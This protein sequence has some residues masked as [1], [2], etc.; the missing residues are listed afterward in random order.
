KMFTTRFFLL[1]LLSTVA[2]GAFNPA[3]AVKDA[4]NGF[5]NTGNDAVKNY[6]LA[7][8]NAFS[9]LAEAFEN[10]LGGGAGVGG[11]ASGAM[12]LPKAT[13]DCIAAALKDTAGAAKTA[14]N[15]LVG[16]AKGAFGDL[17]GGN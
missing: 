7:I 11:V 15:G 17:M 1:L 8:T 16:T 6:A 4:A 10:G 12:A 3:G 2:L 5:L 14:A 9:C 13:I